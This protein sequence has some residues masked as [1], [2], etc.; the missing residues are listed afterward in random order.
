MGKGE[1]GLYKEN[2]HTNDSS[3]CGNGAI[4]V[5]RMLEGCSWLKR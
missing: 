3:V 1:S 4:V 2:W 5:Q